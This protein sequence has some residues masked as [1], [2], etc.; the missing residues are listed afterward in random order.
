MKI[1]VACDHGSFDFNGELKA[2]L[3]K[4]GHEVIDCGTTNKESCD[5]PDFGFLACKKVQGNESERAILSCTNGIGMSMVANKCSGIRA[6]LVYNERTA[7]RTREHHN[8]NVLCLGAQEFSTEELLKMVEVWL[9]TEFEG[10]RHE[11]RVSK[12]PTI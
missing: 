4:Q 11:R 6:A 7:Q 3:E 8:S 2:W 12:F 9:A 1:S 5:Y 10:G